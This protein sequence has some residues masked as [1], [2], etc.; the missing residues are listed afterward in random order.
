MHLVLLAAI[1]NQAKCS[2]SMPNTA[3]SQI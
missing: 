2:S 3:G 1:L